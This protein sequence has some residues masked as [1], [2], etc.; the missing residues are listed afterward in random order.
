[1]ITLFTTAACIPSKRL[2]SLLDSKGQQY[3]EINI[4]LEP[5]RLQE[6]K[7]K[8]KGE[9]YV[10]QIFVNN[11][12]IGGLKVVLRLEEEG[13][14]DT[15][16]RKNRNSALIIP[17]EFLKER[18]A[19]EAP[20][21]V[22]SVEV[23]SDL[24]ESPHINRSI[25]IETLKQQMQQPT[26]RDHHSNSRSARSF[27]PLSL[28]GQ[29]P[30]ES[31]RTKA[32]EGFSSTRTSGSAISRS[33]VT[34]SCSSSSSSSS[35]AQSPRSSGGSAHDFLGA[36]RIPSQGSLPPSRPPP[37][38][39]KKSASLIAEL[40]KT[41]QI[42]TQAQTEAQ[43]QTQTQAQTQSQTQTETQQLSTA[44][45][46]WLREVTRSL[47]E[48]VITSEEEFNE[49]DRL[50]G[51]GDLGL[52]LS[53]G[54]RNILTHLQINTTTTTDTTD[55]TDTDTNT[56]T[57]SEMKS[58]EV[59]EKYD[60]YSQFLAQMASCVQ[61]MGGTSGPLYAL[62]LLGM[63]NSFSSP[64]PPP[65]P[66]T[67]T[68]TAATATATATATPSAPPTVPLHP[69]STRPSSV[70][71]LVKWS[72]AFQAGVAALQKLG[73]A[74]KG[75]RTMLDALLPA[76][77]ALSQA[78]Q[79]ADAAGDAGQQYSYQQVWRAMA[80]AAREGMESTKNMVPKL[81][82]AEYIGANQLIGFPDPGAF[83]IT[84]IILTLSSLL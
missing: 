47:C 35:R 71:V 48:A 82:R 21:S 51:D 79:A 32:P 8:T 45:P 13:F 18:E 52:S 53:R 2:K 69:P 55:T 24:K 81:G 57:D 37:S 9:K 62:F 38:S 34:S 65:P 12:Y 30:T 49:L 59:E 64:P 36:A 76:Y 46:G 58:D 29:I 40:Q 54:A 11:Q 78:A 17:P 80:E 42:Q 33:H 20:R 39:P 67:A 83:A 84:R 19:E 68:A 77:D 72:R 61:K 23:S 27:T 10:P 6:M 31:Q 26:G 7:E 4:F 75:D 25:S 63:A 44:V 66:P 74:K 3:E 70:S 43:T 60:F 1:M 28:S 41:M 56:I 50:C 22:S 16:L 5:E 73:G 15:I 14:L